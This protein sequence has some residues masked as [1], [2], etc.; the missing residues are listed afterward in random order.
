MGLCLNI[1]GFSVMPIIFRRIECIIWKGSNFLLLNIQKIFFWHG[2]FPKI[3][4]F[5]LTF[6]NCFLK[7]KLKITLFSIPFIVS[8]F[9]NRFCN[10]KGARSFHSCL[11]ITLPI[12]S[13][14]TSNNR[15]RSNLS[16]W[17]GSSDGPFAFCAN[18]R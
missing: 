2:P 18:K 14:L 6:K 7:N 10:G 15:K 17:S 13:T 5:F 1:A 3:F 4:L 12:K 11:R 9:E 16:I 8:L